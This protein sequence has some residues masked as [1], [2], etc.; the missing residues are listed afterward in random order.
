M[1][2]FD[3]SSTHEHHRLF[4]FMILFFGGTWDLSSLIRDRTRIA[5]LGSRVSTTGLPGK[6][7]ASLTSHWP[8]WQWFSEECIGQACILIEG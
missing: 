6:S 1:I 3:T 5:C 7:K 8:R 4:F 2:K